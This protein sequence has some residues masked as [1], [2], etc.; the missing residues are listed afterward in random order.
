MESS[1]GGHLA[2]VHRAGESP[3]PSVPAGSVHEAAAAPGTA[4]VFPSETPAPASSPSRAAVAFASPFQ[5][6]FTRKE[7]GRVAS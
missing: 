6:I 1:H 7:G 2:A 4:G 5:F 3:L